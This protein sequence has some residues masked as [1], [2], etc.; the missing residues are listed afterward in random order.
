MA[1]HRASHGRSA[2]TTSAS[3]KTMANPRNAARHPPSDTTI[4]RLMPI[5]N[6]NAISAA[7]AKGFPSR[8][9]R[10]EYSMP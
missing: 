3:G 5:R 1:V 6:G 7:R 8:M 9:S 10:G 4:S 2:H